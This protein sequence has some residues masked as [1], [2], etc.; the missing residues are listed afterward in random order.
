[1][2]TEETQHFL[3]RP[4]PQVKSS[5]SSKVVWVWR[6]SSPQSSRSWHYR[7]HH[8]TPPKVS[9]QQA[10]L[11]ADLTREVQT[12]SCPCP[13]RSW[14]MLLARHHGKG[15]HCKQNNRR[16]SRVCRCWFFHYHRLKHSH[17]N[18]SKKASPL[19]RSHQGDAQSAKGRE[20]GR[21]GGL[22]HRQLGEQI[23][24][25]RVKVRSTSQENGGT[26]SRTA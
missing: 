11:Q 21:E 18:N 20:G 22:A 7:T 17:K 25:Q 23:S 2:I 5:F 1:M 9:P 14:L 15:W 12:T 26:E 10:E 6:H 19:W 3:L 13:S 8:S 4:G 24:H 16:T